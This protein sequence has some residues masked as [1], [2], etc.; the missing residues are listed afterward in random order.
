[1]RNVL[2][3]TKLDKIAAH[4]LENSGYNVLQ[5][6]ETDLMTLVLNHPETEA[7]I[8]RSEK[9]TPEIM[10]ILPKL[11]T[12]VRAGA[13]YDTIDIKYARRKGIDVMNTPGAN[14]NG[15]AEEVFAMALAAYRHV[16]AAD[17]NTR[18]GGWE[19]KKFMGRE[20]TGKTLGIVGLGN[21]GQ[22]VAKHSSGFDMK[23]LAYDP[24]ISSA[25]A[26]DIGVK[27]VD[28]DTLFANSDI[29]TL[30]IPENDETRG[31]INTTLLSKV[32]TGCMLINCSRAGIVNEDDIRALKAEKQLLFCN[33]VYPKDVAGSKSVT[34][35]ADVM[36]PHL[37]ANT[38]EAN[39]VAAKRA[40][41]QLLDYFEKSVTNFVVNK[42]VP[43]GLNAKFQHLAFKLA[44]VARCLI[45]K[46]APISQI[47]CS[48]YGDLNRY[49]KW[50]VAPISA[51]LCD[52]FDPQQAPEEAL[53]F[54]KDR[55]INYESRAVDEQKRYGNAMTIDLE[56]GSSKVSLRGTIT[57]NTLMIT[58]IDDFNRVYLVPQGNVLI[59]EYTDRPGVL[60]CITA[61]CA[62]AGVNIEDIHAPRNSEG[63]DAIA[64]LLTDKQVSNAVV[65]KI[66]NTVKSKKAV[67]ISIP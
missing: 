54:L 25:K 46:N 45:G 63:T 38:K 58:R 6:S 34:D 48:F 49:D 26:E 51:A 59:V 16:I 39:F 4:L 40:A 57:E 42:G 61:C 11:R 20:L 10:D 47:R 55:G 28:L 67:S 64:I 17:I 9:I 24:I 2:I 21:I 52:N 44:Y 66:K 8:V 15:V 3:P 1:M 35:I 22:L 60:A 12:I 32:K 29:I 41:E 62:E 37:G 65:D 56:T 31:M 19:K 7:M 27:L 53:A 14:S 36:L 23:L 18:A 30:H 33:D 50:F 43:D 5:D 13:G